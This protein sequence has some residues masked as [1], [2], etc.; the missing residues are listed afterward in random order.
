MYYNLSPPFHHYHTDRF[1]AIV[2]VIVSRDSLQCQSLRRRISS[3]E[4]V[5][6]SPR[7]IVSSLA[8]QSP[9]ESDLS[10]QYDHFIK[11][12]IGFPF[13]RLDIIISTR[14]IARHS[15]IIM[16]AKIRVKI[17]RWNPKAKC[18]SSLM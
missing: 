15:S 2:F 5:M 8:C 16:I 18:S 17:F 3:G 14:F 1:T 9:S 11:M 4:I 6:P 12:R 7:T 10:V 13:V